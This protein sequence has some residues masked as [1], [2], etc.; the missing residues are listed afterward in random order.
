MTIRAFDP[1]GLDGST[2]FGQT[3]QH[4]V[5][6]AELV[7]DI[8]P[9]ARLVLAAYRTPAQ[10]EE[11]ADWIAAQGIPIVSHSNSFLTPPFDGTGRA[12]RAVDRAAA[13]GVLWVNSAGNYAQRHWRGT[14]PAEGVVIPIAPAAGSPLLF[15]LSWPS[16]DAAASV[17]VERQDA[18]GVWAEVQRSTTAPSPNATGAGP[19]YAAT[20]P[21]LADAAPWRL[22]VRQECGRAA[23]LDAVLLHGRIRARSPWPTGASPRPGT[24]PVRSPWGP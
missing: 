21:I 13:A 20:T 9:A 23:A 11:A 5:R 3:T 10:F 14:A 6:M 24:P 16:A 15:S 12:A 19:M 22:V 8:A 7:H 17:A 4:G 18:A 1:G 2:E